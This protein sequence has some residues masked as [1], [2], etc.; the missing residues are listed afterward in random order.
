MP[1]M[2]NPKRIMVFLPNWVGDAVM[3]TPSLAALR[4][5]LVD[6]QI[7]F[8][9]K[10]AV[11]ETLAGAGLADECIPDTSTVSPRLINMFRL[12]RQ[13]R[14]IR[15]DVALLLPNSFRAAALAYASG[16]RK[17]V[18]YNRDGRGWLL[19]DTHLPLRDVRGRY[20]PVPTIDYY[21]RLMSLLNVDVP[22]RQMSLAVTPEG[23]AAADKLLAEAGYD[24]ARPLV[25]L[26]PGGAFGPS[27]MWETS[28]YAEVADEVVRRWNGQIIVNSAP[29]EKLIAENLAHQ[30][31]FPPLLNFADR[32]NS[33]SLLKS[34]LRRCRLLITNDTGARHIGV[35]MGI[36]VVAIFASTDPRWTELH[37]PRER[38]VCTSVRCAPCQDK[39]CRFPAGPMYQQ[40]TRAITTEMV[41]TAVEDLMAAPQVTEVRS[42]DAS[43]GVSQ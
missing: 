29:G 34:M 9:G 19:T 13:L 27:K 2:P 25:M 40:C 39:F 15:P 28:S 12:A 31:K 14:R 18:G 32:P 38:S 3:A 41:L 4:A 35:A 26:N 20:V 30:M 36:D 1:H 11:L 37:Y 24:P 23:E 22:S 42:P 7:W 5:S 6:W 33:L 17:R 10:P 21:A 43:Q 16:A 8:V